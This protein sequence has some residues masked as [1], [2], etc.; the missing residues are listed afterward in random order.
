L[1]YSEQQAPTAAQTPG[2]SAQTCPVCGRA[3]LTDQYGFVECGCGWGGPDD[4]VES[5]R[6][7]SRWLTLLDRRLATSVARRELARIA[8]TKSAASS[9][10]LLYIAALSALSAA[11]YLIIGAL[12]VG[13][14]ILL[15]QYLLAEVWLG[16]VLGGVI[17]L[18]LFWTLF[19]FPQRIAG[20]VTPL[21]DYPRLAATLGEVAARV[22]V[23]TP[24]WVILFPGADFYIVRRMLWGRALTPQIVV[25]NGVPCLA[26]M[27]DREL[28]AVLAHELAHYQHEHTFFGRFFGGAESALY[29]IID[30]VKAGIS[31]QYKRDYLAR[32]RSSSSLATT[33]GVL[34]IW[35]VTLPLRLLWFVFHLLRLR[36]SHANE[37]EADATA[38][39]A[40]GPQAFINGL[41]AVRATAATMRG[42][43]QGIRQEMVKRNNPNFFAELRRHYAELPADYLGQMRVKTLRGYRTL[44]SSHPITPDRI[45]AALL[46]GAPE[47]PLTLAPQPVS[48]IITPAGAPDASGVERQ[49]TDLLFASGQRRR[50]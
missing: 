36:L 34:V 13:S 41:A 40:Y 1:E 31:T 42:A 22:G 33:A 5:A 43:R 48:E 35:V 23:K 24:R 6:G 2:A 17:V 49:L 15:A 18:Y 50:R 27:N 9:R 4:P 3:A 19:G 10:S 44:E 26:Q 39:E 11:I 16:A 21:S 25:G 46:L 45:R 12:F 28:R 8:R 30:G 37:Y 29:N 32:R 14:V 7:A 47:P 38:I 20:I